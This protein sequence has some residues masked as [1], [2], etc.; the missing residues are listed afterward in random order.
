MARRLLASLVVVALSAVA[1][2]AQQTTSNYKIV[3]EVQE[4]VRENYLKLSGRVELEQGD[5]K[6]YAD[7]LEWFKDQDRA[8]A[9]GNVVFSQGNNSIA[10]DRADI[11]TKS[12]VGT[13]YD[14]T[15]IANIQPPRQRPTPGALMLPPAANQETDV[16]FFGSVVEKIGPKKYKITNG[17]FST[18]VQPTPRWDLHADTVVLNIDHYTLLRQVIFQVKGVPLFYTPLLYYPTKQEG[19][20]TGILIPTYG[21]STIRG[22]SIHNAFFWAI[23]RS[24]DATF[25]HD[26]YSKTGQ[27][28]GSEYRYSLASGDGNMR[29]ELI[30]EHEASYPGGGMLPARRSFE[31]RGNA[32]QTLSE[33][34]RARGNIDYFSSVATMQSFNTN[35]YDAS[36]SRRTYGGNIVGAW[37]SYS[38]NGTFD[39]VENF[40]TSTS[41]VVSGSTPRIA[42]TRNE[43]PLFSGSQLY[44]SAGT[45][46]VHFDRQSH[47]GTAAFDS[48]LSR[49]DFAP[50]IRYP[51]KKWQW[52][53]VSTTLLWRDTFYT[54]SEDPSARDPLTGQ[55]VILDESLNR[56]YL[57]VVAQ[58]IGPVFT[59][60]W[61]TPDSSYAEKF[62]H[63]IE[64][65]FV[66]QRSSSVDNFD[67]IVKTDGIDQV[68]GTTSYSYGVN[69][70]FYAKRKVGAL[71]QA[72]EIVTV[73]LTQS[74]YTNSL[75]A[76]YD[77]TYQTSLN[78]SQPSRFSPVR[79]DVRAMPTTSVNG[80][81]HAEF[82]SRYREL[83]LVTVNGTYNWLT[84]LQTTVGW[85][86]KFFIKE[87]E[88]FNDPTR[89]DHYL[90][91]QANAQTRDNRL[92]ARYSFN[93]DVLHSTMLQQSITGFYNAQCCGIAVQYQRF[94]FG[95]IS[96]FS[97]LPSDHRFFLSFTL[98]GL[99]NFS[100][101]NGAMNGVPR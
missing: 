93:Y 85:T 87:L 73:S 92:G 11:N 62:K 77:S 75:A 2:E 53:T 12:H 1:A 70:R 30:N 99:G 16:Y 101:L 86:H 66:V 96:G 25:M 10:A 23:D 32:S 33:S 98:A 56:Q 60:V 59:R 43:R 15:G 38:L 45:E 88:G 76:Q 3:A 81:F 65:V 50:Q 9:T 17:G 31:L 40:Y 24:H 79:L 95:G 26:W 18:C 48:G 7:H 41:S 52:F 14:A 89:L 5:T 61:D 80:T 20:A 27:A 29:G 83:R 63:S 57:A 49:F 72:V 74:H 100:P 90:N 34:L 82:D 47:E 64:P 13:F 58:A 4:Q 36:R 44:F 78:A 42:F 8:I 94:N 84:Q 21:S 19:R 46:F 67:R 35:I 55:P 97:L 39:W 22:Q 69:N 68:V 54:R 28:F 6:L 71:S 91:A 51:F 37:P